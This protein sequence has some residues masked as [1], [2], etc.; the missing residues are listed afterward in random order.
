M[1]EL[2]GDDDLVGNNIICPDDE[3]LLSRAFIFR[4]FP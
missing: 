2:V 1:D 4:K 3:N